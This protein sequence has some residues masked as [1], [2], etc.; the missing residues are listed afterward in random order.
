MT[1]KCPH[2]AHLCSMWSF[3]VCIIVLC[4]N[5]QYKRSLMTCLHVAFFS[6]S[7]HI[8]HFWDVWNC[9]YL[10]CPFAC[11]SLHLIFLSA[12]CRIARRLRFPT[13]CF[14]CGD[15]WPLGWLKYLTCILYLVAQHEPVA[16]HKSQHLYSAIFLSVTLM[17]FIFVLH[18]QCSLSFN[19]TYPS[20]DGSSSCGTFY[21][22]PTFF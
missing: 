15:L 20:L 17:L 5:L 21:F 7:N 16:L 13:V 2:E 10:M 3:S 6:Q 9:D 18:G 1:L 8:V 11:V 4:N 22:L 14:L 12:M 19:Q